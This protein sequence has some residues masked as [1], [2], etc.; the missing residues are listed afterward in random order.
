MIAIQDQVISANNYK[1][2]ILKD[3]NITN[4]ICKKSQKNLEIKVCCCAADQ[5]DYT[6]DHNEVANFVHQELVIKCALSNEP[7]IPYYTLEPQSVLENSK[8]KQ[9]Y[10]K[11]TITD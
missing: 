6:H 8:Y 3:L 5:G 4:D 2:H 11:S 10:D 7:P 1:K 9:Y